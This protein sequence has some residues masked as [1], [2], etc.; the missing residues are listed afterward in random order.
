MTRFEWFLPTKPFKINQVWGI[1]NP[2]YQQF[3]FSRHNG[4][5]DGIATG[6][7][8]LCPQDGTVVTVATKENGKW[9]PNGGGN[10]VSIVTN[11]L[12]MFDDG[13][14]AYV[15]IDFLHCK[16]ISVVEGQQVIVGDELAIANNTGFSTGPHTHIQFRRVDNPK[17]LGVI[18]KNDANNSID[19][20]P[21]CNNVYAGAWVV[22]RSLQVTLQKILDSLKGRP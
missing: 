2:A 13:D 4:I 18:D 7:P 10:Y 11:D 16:S 6:T 19:P 14:A 1:F 3:G 21:Y 22:L 12:W 15:L 20:M 5:D 8:L 17:T 9:Q